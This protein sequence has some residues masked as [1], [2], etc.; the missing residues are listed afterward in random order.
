MRILSNL[1][2]L[3][4]RAREFSFH[5]EKLFSRSM[6]VYK[7]IIENLHPQWFLKVII[8]EN[9]I[10]LTVFWDRFSLIPH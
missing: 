2:F 7:A 8:E 6:L 3:F 4:E 9:V 5:S 1:K 10:N